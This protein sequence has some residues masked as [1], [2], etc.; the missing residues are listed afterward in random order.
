MSATG[1]W[2]CTGLEIRCIPYQEGGAEKVRE[3]K[4]WIQRM[5]RK[6]QGKDEMDDCFAQSSEHSI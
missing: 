2:S 6:P 1:N 5:V 3:G 4:D